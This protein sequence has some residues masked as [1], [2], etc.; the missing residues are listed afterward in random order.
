MM[1]TKKAE[2]RVAVYLATMVLLHGFL[3]YKQWDRIVRGFPDFSIFYTAAQ[4]F[5]QGQAAHIYNDA[6]QERV[7]RSFAPAVDERESI[8]PY[9]HPPFEAILFWPFA[10]LSFIQA[11]VVWLFIN[12]L[13]LVASVATL[14][15]CLPNLGKVGL[16]IWLLAA[17]GFTPF[18]IALMQGQDSILLFLFYCLALA[19]LQKRRD[20]WA[21]ICLGF[22]LFKFHLVLPFMVGP[23]AQRRWRL[24]GAFAATGASLVALSIA[25]VGWEAVLDYPRYAWW[26]DHVQKFRWNFLHGNTPNLRGMVLS[27]L[28]KHLWPSGEIVVVIASAMVVLGAGYLWW[29]GKGSVPGLRLVFAASVVATTLVSYHAW[30]QDLSLLFLPLMVL[31][32]FHL[33]RGVRL[34]ET[35]MT[36][37]LSAICFCT[38]IYLGLILRYEQLQVMG[39][40]ILLLL[41]MIGA[42]VVGMRSDPQALRSE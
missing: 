17:F 2:R 27:L 39:W 10:K 18:V 15:T 37:G 19:A 30:V 16:W 4:I 35:V 24:I 42:G 25:L 14:R 31:L 26:T 12:V 8:L 1:I 6:L 20:S 5:H 9:N 7:Q 11:Y 32:D 21:G 23:L 28:P 33:Q 13:L 40:I 36:W 3:F 22:G 38:P 34:K 29:L 41:L